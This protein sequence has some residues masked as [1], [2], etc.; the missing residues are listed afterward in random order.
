MTQ[1]F[2]QLRKGVPGPKA[3]LEAGSDWGGKGGK[4]PALRGMLLQC[5]FPLTNREG[6]S[7]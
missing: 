4:I 6:E 2:A 7:A 1:D 5:M 3:V